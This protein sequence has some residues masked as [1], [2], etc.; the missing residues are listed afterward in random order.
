MSV[1][2]LGI[3]VIQFYWLKNNIDLNESNFNHKV[4]STLNRVKQ[5]LEDDAS[6]LE[7]FSRSQDKSEWSI[8][9]SENEQLD[10]VINSSVS[11]YRRDK[12]K[13][14]I[15]NT[16]WFLEPQRALNNISP[17]DL[18][19]YLR[20][21]LKDHGIDLEYDYG[22]FS[23]ELED[24]MIT[25]GAF[26]VVNV[27]G[28]MSD[29]GAAD[30]LSKSMYQVNLFDSEGKKDVGSLRIFFPKKTTFVIRSVLPALISSIL[31]TG[32]ILFC[33]VY[34]INVILT[35]KKVS[36]MKTDFINN[37]TH[38]FKTPIA[39]I[40]LA[41]DSIT[42]PMVKSNEKMID[43]YAGIIKQ[44][45]KRMLKQVEKVLQIARLDKE[46][47]ELKVVTV[48][49]NDAVNTAVANSR[50]R[51][52]KREGQ[53]N[54]YLRSINPIIKGDENHISNVLHNLI[55][56]AIKYSPNAPVITLETKDIGKGVEVTISDE[57]I[58]MSK[59]DLKR[60]FEKFYRV[61]TG[62][63]HD[64]KGFGLGLSYVKAITDAH[65]GSVQVESEL[66]KGSIFK[67]YLPSD[68]ERTK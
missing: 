13:R 44:E 64:V 38:E 43:R 15:A 52:N 55:D 63:L 26:N 50:L 60:I 12:Y 19:R 22:V 39:T 67:I 7:S 30:R 32:L 41:A 51:I 1:A 14:E 9:K 57:G 3:S 35:Q 4:N 21:E 42:N 37:M 10:R 34:T 16:V 17:A 48:N 25:N 45:N 29:G 40:S 8:F 36:I 62:N 61:S 5:K 65:N 27:T 54:A 24:Y 6:Q 53:I 58:G 68:F 23:N 66:G 2:L 33:F 59:D 31:L 46:D 49:L 20:I 18:S 11:Q 56:N 28:S 47:F